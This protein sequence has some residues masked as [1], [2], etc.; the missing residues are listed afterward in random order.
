MLPQVYLAASHIFKKVLILISLFCPFKIPIIFHSPDNIK[1][2]KVTGISARTLLIPR[3]ANNSKVV[4]AYFFKNSYTFLSGNIGIQ[5]LI[6]SFVPGTAKCSLPLEY[7]SAVA[8]SAI[9]I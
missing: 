5:L 4:G 8:I 6:S 7:S 3:P 2:S 9:L 1:D